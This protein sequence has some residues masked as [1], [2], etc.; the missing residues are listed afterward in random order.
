MREFLLEILSE[1]IPARMQV[2]AA[3]DLKR[4]VIEQLTAAGL[5]FETATAHSTPRRLALVIEGLP[6]SSPDRSE[7]RKGP[8]VGSPEGAV[9]GFLKSSGLASIDQAE[10]RE[11]D[12]GATYFAVRTLPGLP[13]E[14][15]LSQAIV[16]A[17]DTLPWPKSMRWAS[18]RRRWVR[19]LTGILAILDGKTIALTGAVDLPAAGNTTI[20]H[21]FLGPEAFP[22]ANFHDYERKLL[23]HFVVLDREKRKWRIQGDSKRLADAHGLNVVL[24]EALLE[25]VVGLVEWPVVL[26]GSIDD[27]FMTL[28]PEVRRTT[29][30]A[31]Q[32]YF[33]LEH[34]DGK[35]AARFLIVANMEAEDGGA[36]IVSGNERV[37]RARLAD[38]R[39]FYDQDRKVKLADQRPKLDKI[40]FHAKL[41]SVLERVERLEN[42]SVEIAK[43]V[44]D[45]E[46]TMA[47]EAAALCKCDLVSGMVGEFPELQG[48]MGRYYALEEDAPHQVADAIRDH[49][50]P[51]GPHDACPTDPVSVVLALAEKIDTL[52]GFFAIGELPTGSKDPFALRRA[53]L[54]VIRLIVENNI[55]LPLIYIFKFS[56]A[57]FSANPN[58]G[59]QWRMRAF[60]QSLEPEFSGNRVELRQLNLYQRLY[61][62]EIFLNQKLGSDTAEYLKELKL[63]DSNF[64]ETEG[65]CIAT[66]LLA[67]F[68]DRLK[69]LLKER[70]VRHDLVDAVFALGGEDDLVRLLSRVQALQKFLATDDGINL[71]SAY[72]RA[73]NILKIEEKRDGVSYDAAP[74]P[75]YLTQ[76]EELALAN[77][78]D[79]T[80]AAADRL[81]DAEKF[82]EAMIEFATLRPVVDAFFEHVTVN[83]E[84]PEIRA[85]RLRLL[86]RIRGTLNKIA[87]FSKV[88]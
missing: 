69:V 67:F 72:R 86:S 8:K 25:E 61:Y 41:G 30:R 55:K 22:V 82:E 28:P 76:D 19:P 27:D 14:T 43:Y 48:L 50:K 33:T 84:A 24:D 78:L 18:G 49:Y 73:A 87:D 44:P 66:E 63:R 6:E 71:L 52:V 39:F 88:A 3:E 75:E 20:G 79:A 17:I 70:G 10:I 36:A 21:R 40:A 58:Y 29:M 15:V 60:L 54:G 62:D 12:K 65:D 23:E 35:P 5:S 51:L 81:I 7:E 11:T 59:L 26:M 32:K 68:A 2:Q 80:G 31:N 47:V 4:L 74:D 34:Q 45:A 42:L 64:I 83:A 16:A 77:A 85:N 56:F 1:D 38:A 9:Q 53:A 13:T 46:A 37:L 57:P